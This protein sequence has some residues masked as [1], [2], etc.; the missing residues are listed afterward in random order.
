MN[1]ETKV[2]INQAVGGMFSEGFTYCKPPVGGFRREGK[3][4]CFSGVI[5]LGGVLYSVTARWHDSF[6]GHII[7]APVD[8]RPIK[9]TTRPIWDAEKYL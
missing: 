4:D 9:T 7:D 2:K 1:Y 8:A 6:D 3:Y 5:R